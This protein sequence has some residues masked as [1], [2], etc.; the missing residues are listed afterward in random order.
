MNFVNDLK[1]GYF[2]ISQI[3]VNPENNLLAIASSDK[4]IGIFNLNNLNQDPMIIENLN[5]QVRSLVFSNENFLV[6]G[7]ENGDC[8]F[9]STITM[10]NISEICKHISRTLSKD[11]WEKYIGNKIKIREAC[12]M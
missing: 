5:H 12:K 6:A 7:F 1:F 2:P 8:R 10:K 3:N 9:W 11:E 4:R